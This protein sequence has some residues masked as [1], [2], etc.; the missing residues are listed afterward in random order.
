MTTLFLAFDESIDT[1]GSNIVMLLVLSLVVLAIRFYMISPGQRHRS[2]KQIEAK[3]AQD[4]K[5]CSIAVFLG[6]GQCNRLRRY[7]L[8]S[9]YRRAYQ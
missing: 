6:S 5:K 8:N 3:G 1:S 7:L 4:T 2:S 9:A